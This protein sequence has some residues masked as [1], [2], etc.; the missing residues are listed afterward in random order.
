[1]EAKINGGRHSRSA[2]LWE[3]NSN[4]GEGDGEGEE[5][6]FFPAGKETV[7]TLP[8]EINDLNKRNYPLFNKQK[9]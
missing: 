9:G 8:R 2:N 6:N 5:I 1:M 7:I 4:D 3:R